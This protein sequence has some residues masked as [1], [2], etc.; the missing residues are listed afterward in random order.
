MVNLV[1]PARMSLDQALEF[2]REDECV[3]VTPDAV[4]LR[5]VAADGDRSREAGPLGAQGLSSQCGPA[6]RGGGP[7]KR[8]VWVPLRRSVAEP[9]RL[10]ASPAVGLADDSVTG[11]THLRGAAR[12]MFVGHT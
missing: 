2:I 1:P 9:L 5:K 4:R 10:I 11:L 8:R 3:E 7:P 12:A 6:T